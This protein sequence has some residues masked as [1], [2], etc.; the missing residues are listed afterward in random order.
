MVGRNTSRTCVR[1]HDIVAAATL[2]GHASGFM[3]ISPAA[4]QRATLSAVC[5]APLGGV[6]LRAASVDSADVD[7]LVQAGMS[8]ETA[9]KVLGEGKTLTQV[10]SLM[11]IRAGP[12]YA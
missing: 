5:Q 2:L 12:L 11:S 4:V 3:T 1:F 10:I 7:K 6:A 8:R 9:G